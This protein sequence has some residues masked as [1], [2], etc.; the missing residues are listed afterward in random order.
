[1]SSRKQ[2]HKPKKQQKQK[3]KQKTEVK[4]VVK[5]P[6]T[7][8][9]QPRRMNNS[10]KFWKL[11]HSEL[12]GSL[13]G[14]VAWTK[15]AVIWLGA[16]NQTNLPWLA[17]IA[18]QFESYRFDYFR[19]RYVTRSGTQSTG[20]VQFIPEYNIEASGPAD[21]VKAA[22]YFNSFETPI[23]QNNV[24]SADRKSMDNGR[25]E[26]FVAPIPDGAPD[27]AAKGSIPYWCGKVY[28]YTEGCANTDPVGKLFVEYGVTL[29]TPQ[30]STLL[31]EIS[32]LT[33][34][35]ALTSAD[36]A[37]YMKPGPPASQRDL[38]SPFGTELSHGSTQSMKAAYPLQQVLDNGSGYIP[39]FT[40]EGSDH[41]NIY[42]LTFPKVGQYVLSI[43]L[44]ALIPTAQMGGSDLL[45]YNQADSINGLTSWSFR[46]DTVVTAVSGGTTTVNFSFNA[47]VNVPS[48]DEEG[49]GLLSWNQLDV[50]DN[51]T[52][53]IVQ[54][55]TTGLWITDSKVVIGQM[56]V[57]Y[58]GPYPPSLSVPVPERKISKIRS[59][60]RLGRK[61]ETKR[62]DFIHF[63][64]PESVTVVPNSTAPPLR[65]TPSSSSSS[66]S[67]PISNLSTAPSTPHPRGSLG[68]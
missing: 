54:N 55:E 10:R 41:Q 28:I 38:Y 60:A 42:C 1:M 11:E 43:Q 53:N 2:V 21:E 29:M 40:F 57:A 66:F 49:Y 62:P 23:W 37:G 5:G 68:L 59:S 16:G 26:H 13:N 35:L 33:D 30:Y 22:S 18:S 52:S 14:S 64:F 32:T 44:Y 7:S 20:V 45:Q 12:I 39:W 61:V 4:V 15:Q 36:W 50:L 51:N 17:T 67:L 3:Q 19:I 47:L 65:D 46:G 63:P 31:S 56:T 58:C 9:A 34:E 24:F 25:T 27:P 6:P 8:M 48:L